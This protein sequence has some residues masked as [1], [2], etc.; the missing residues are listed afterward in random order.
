MH[1]AMLIAPQ[2]KAQEKIWFSHHEHQPRRNW[3]AWS[4]PWYLLPI[5][6]EE[7]SCLYYHPRK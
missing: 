7:S 5:I 2:D 1:H 4:N 6:C 3:N